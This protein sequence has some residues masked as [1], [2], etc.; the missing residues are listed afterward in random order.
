MIPPTIDAKLDSAVADLSVGAQRLTALG[1]PERCVLLDSCAS[2]VAEVAELWV[3]AACQ[4]KRI[5]LDQA[6][7]GEK[8]LAGPCSVMRYL[9][10]L[11]RIFQDVDQTGVPR[12]PAAPRE[13]SLGRLCVS[14]MPIGHLY[15]RLIFR[16]LRCEVWPQRQAFL[17]MVDAV[18]Q[19]IPPRF[20]YYP[21]DRQRFEH[22]AG[23]LPDSNDDSLPWTLIRGTQRSEQP[24]LFDEESFVCVCAETMLDEASCEAFL[25]AAVDFVNSQL[26]G[27]LGITFTVTDAFRQRQANHLDRA[28]DRLRYG[29]VCI[30]QWSGIADVSIRGQGMDQT[31]I[32][33]TQQSQGSGSE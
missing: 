17:D 25:D 28:I 13:N 24:H 1:M 2:S 33:F 21:G 9:R 32:D 3:Q 18:L 5:A 12:L 29:T 7:A 22:A 14:V 11:Q 6:I 31:I 19:R 20:A 16:G 8:I 4:A 26:F 23:R 10:V 27:T 15:D 30:N